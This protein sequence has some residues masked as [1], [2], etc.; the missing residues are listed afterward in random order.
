M[1]LDWITN[2]ARIR[3]IYLM[4]AAQ[5]WR[6]PKSKPARYLLDDPGAAGYCQPTERSIQRF[7]H[8]MGELP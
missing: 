3:G 7:H 1:A 5:Q 2:L 4:S 6:R 8:R